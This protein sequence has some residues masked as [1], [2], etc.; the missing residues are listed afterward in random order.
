MF[1]LK[2]G[3]S[4]VARGAAL[5]VVPMVVAS[6]GGSADQNLIRNAP[7]PSLA[8]CTDSCAGVDDSGVIAK[9][10]INSEAISIR[11]ATIT[12]NEDTTYTYSDG[13]RVELL[14]GVIGGYEGTD[15]IIGEDYTGIY[16]QLAYGL[17]V[18]PDEAFIGVF[19]RHTD[20]DAIRLTGQAFYLGDALILTGFSGED[21][22]AASVLDVDFGA[23]TAD[24][25]AYTSELGT[26]ATFDEIQALNMQVDGYS[27]TGDEM[28]FL[29]ESENVNVTGANTDSAAAGL[30]FGT[31]DGLG[32]PAEFGA[33]GV[34]SGDSDQVILIANGGFIPPP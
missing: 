17:A 1:S 16:S 25:Y 15:M 7:N 12:D 10:D 31:V 13:Q 33:V 4:V 21:E 23:K 28:V 20:A 27:F 3:K 18:D 9:I 6:C 14:D 24:L 30:F 26:I 32:N 34:A 5:F 22:F 2:S 8:G 29:L 19:G 11:F